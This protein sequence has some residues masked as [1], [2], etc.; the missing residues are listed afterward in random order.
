MKIELMISLCTED[1][2]E[3]IIVLGTALERLENEDLQQKL[4]IIMIENQLSRFTESSMKKRAI[5][6]YE[7]YSKRMLGK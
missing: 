6:Y 1:D 5:R 2:K 4:T 7:M 3:D